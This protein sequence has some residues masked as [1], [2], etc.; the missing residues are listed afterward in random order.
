MFKC[1]R[2]FEFDYAHRLLN[3][4]GHCGN[5][6]GHRAKVIIEVKS[7]LNEKNDGLDHVGRVI[8]FSVIKELIGKWID[9][10]WDHNSIIN[11]EDKELMS[12]S[13]L[14]GFTKR[15]FIMSGNPTSELMAEYLLKTACP[16]LLGPIRIKATKVTFYETPSCYA[17]ASCE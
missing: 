15:P 11:I 2:S 17:E 10:N 9:E 3:H 16:E 13:H 5:L 4:G 6:H 1:A 12:V 7:M 8:D 14:F